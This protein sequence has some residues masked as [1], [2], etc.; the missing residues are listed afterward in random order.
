MNQKEMTPSEN[1]SA[2]SYDSPPWWYDIR[3]FFILTFAYNDT[4]WRQVHFFSKNVSDNHLEA[5]VGTGSLLAIVMKYLK[6]IKGRKPK[7]V[8]AIDYADDMLK[9]AQKKL[10]NLNLK[11]F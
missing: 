8:I 3:G 1:V 7:N 6:W 10:K 11:H 9:G 4:L 2:K 5:A